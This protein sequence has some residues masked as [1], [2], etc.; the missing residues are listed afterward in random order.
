V[1]SVS[2]PHEPQFAE[3]PVYC[4]NSVYDVGI[5]VTLIF[6]EAESLFTND[7]SSIS[8]TPFPINVL[9]CKDSLQ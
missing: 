8:I 7:V 4:H 6:V 1:L 9:R 5:A 2:R 3:L